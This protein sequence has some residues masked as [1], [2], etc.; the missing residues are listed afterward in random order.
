MKVTI[1]GVGAIGGW[2][3]ALLAESGAEVSAVARGRTLQVLQHEGLTLNQEGRTV[4]VRV[5]ATDD[6]ANLGAQDLVVIAVKAPSLLDVARSLG[7]LV[8]ADTMVLTAMNGLPWWFFQGIKGPLA[9]TGLQSVDPG[10]LIANAIPMEHVIGCVVH[11]SCQLDAPGVVRHHAGKALYIGEPTGGVSQRVERLGEVLQRAGCETHLSA[12]I[13]SPTWYKLWG[14]LTINPISALTGATID[15]IIGDELVW[16]FAASVMEEAKRVGARLG[17]EIKETPQDRHDLLRSLGAF[18]S[19]MLQDV[20]ARR[21]L[22]IDALVTSVTE[23][24]RL[25]DEPTPFVDA[26]LGLVRLQSRERGLY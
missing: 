11:A 26:M 17:I 18:K 23:V 6:P 16:R 7:S 12:F 22:E 24:A 2:L 15:R 14:N 9:R 13:Q 8:G 10:G 19:S 21:P 5:N 25:V 3:G 4:R 20:E 1:Y